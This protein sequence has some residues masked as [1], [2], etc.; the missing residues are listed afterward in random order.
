MTVIYIYSVNWEKFGQLILR[1]VI[2]IVA[3]R[4]HILRLKIHQI[5]FRLGL[6]P[7][8]R[9]GSLQRS[10]NPL[11]GL[12]GRLLRR[13]RE[14]RKGKGGEGKKRRE[15]GRR[16]KRRRGRGKEGERVDPPRIL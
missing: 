16:R 8:P 3:M 1:K 9:W 12:K 15:K 7:R 13:G 2:Q 4:C 10:P 6:C 14:G 5:R 11:A